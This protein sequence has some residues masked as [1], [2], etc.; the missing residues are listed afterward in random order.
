MKF[1]EIIGQEAIIN[2]LKE[3]VELGKIP[4]AVMFTGIEGCGLMPLAIAFAQ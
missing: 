2:R 4:H 3:A 1:S